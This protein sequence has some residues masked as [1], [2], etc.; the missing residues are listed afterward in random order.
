MRAKLVVIVT[1]LLLAACSG[2]GAL[3]TS[4]RDLTAPLPAGWVVVANSETA[5]TIADRPLPENP[6]GFSTSAPRADRPDID[7]LP[8]AGIYFT[9]EPS[10]AP[11]DWRDLIAGA[12]DGTVERDESI[13]V[14]G[15]PATLL[16]FSH[17]SGGVATREMVVLIPS[18]GVV[19][20]AQPIGILA[21]TVEGAPPP[22]PGLFDAHLDEFL[23]IID[24]ISFGAPLR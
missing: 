8:E 7:V 22:G 18:R 1:A 16:Q 24:A 9:Y 20:I 19:L 4:W 17:E 14:D 5:F 11:D 3:S 13:E 10:T 21:R 15:I 23:A 12:L 2:G 6:D